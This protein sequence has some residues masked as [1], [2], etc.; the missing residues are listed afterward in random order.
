MPPTV[1]VSLVPLA[2]DRVRRCGLLP[3]YLPL[4]GRRRIT[5]LLPL[6]GRQRRR[7]GGRAVLANIALA[8]LKNLLLLLML[9]VLVTK[10]LL[11]EL[12]LLLL[13]L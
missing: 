13:L 7:R 10:L 6:L 1:I 9:L 3:L 2:V 8:V 5:P 4:L 12:L 11:M